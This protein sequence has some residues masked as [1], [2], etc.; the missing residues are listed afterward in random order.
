MKI[1]S[2]K[3]KPGGLFRRRYVLVELTSTTYKIK[4]QGRYA[5]VV[6]PC[7]DDEKSVLIAVYQAT[8]EWLNGA[9]T[10]RDGYTL[11]R[12]AKRACGVIVSN[13]DWPQDFTADTEA[14]LYYVLDKMTKAEGISWQI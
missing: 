8:W 10:D 6:P 12:G 7:R 3:F 13:L 11:D 9:K 2:I 5:T 14:R 1:T 4:R